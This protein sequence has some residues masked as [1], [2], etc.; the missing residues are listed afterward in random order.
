MAELSARGVPVFNTPG[1]NANAVK[2][3]VL[4]GMLIAARNLD[5]ALGFVDRLDPGDPE[6]ER[7]SRPARRSSPATSWPDTPWA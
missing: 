1:A 2:E 4:S 3:L 5:A 6:L 7:A